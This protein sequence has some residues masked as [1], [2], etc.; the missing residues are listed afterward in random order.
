[1]DFL[2]AF[3]THFAAS[4]LLLPFIAIASVASAEAASA[5][6][7]NT[8]VTFDA[9]LSALPSNSGVQ[10]LDFGSSNATGLVTSQ[11]LYF[12]QGDTIQ[13]SGSA[14]VY[15]GTAA[16][17]AAAPWT[18]SGTQ[19]TNYLAAEPNGGSV[20]INYAEDQRYFGLNW[21]SVDAYNTLSFYENG[22]LVEQV[23]GSQVNAGAN[24]SQSADGSDVVN[25]AFNN[26]AA[27]NKVV[28]S[29]SSP[30]FEFDTVASSTQAIPLTSTGGGAATVLSVFTDASETKT[31]VG[32]APLP[33]LGSSPL[34]VLMLAG[35]VLMA[36]HRRTGRGG[37]L[38]AQC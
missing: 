8:N 34:A 11:E 1:M 23:T 37:G 5:A 6:V 20:T 18:S 25:F 22:A 14:G 33:A 7:L 24:G 2:G 29:S 4:R 32:E 12:G 26:G 38:S 16:G 27:Y 28:L 9:S 21:G 19:T 35:G 13:F 17:V 30:A 36:F 3:M 31:L 15:K 10:L